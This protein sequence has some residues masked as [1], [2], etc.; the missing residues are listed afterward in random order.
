VTKTDTGACLRRGCNCRAFRTEHRLLRGCCDAAGDPRQIKSFAVPKRERGGPSAAAAIVT[1]WR[2]RTRGRKDGFSDVSA[3]GAPFS[4]FLA[5]TCR[6]R[7]G[8]PAAGDITGIWWANSYSPSMKTYLVGGGDIPL[9]EA[10]RKNMPRTRP[11]LKDGRSS[12]ARAAIA[13]RTDCRE[14]SRHPTRSRSSTV[15]KGR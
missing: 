10:G 12:T 5:G 6:Q 15:R 7:V 13:R 3:A 11:G 8:A 1:F 4:C 9:N 2:I 14:R